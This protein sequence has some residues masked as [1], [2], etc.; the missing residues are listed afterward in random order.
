MRGSAGRDADTQTHRDVE[1]Q[2]LG[3]RLSSDGGNVAKEAASFT[4]LTTAALQ[5]VTAQAEHTH[6]HTQRERQTL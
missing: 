2:R 1:T 3:K 5:S 6:T 4:D